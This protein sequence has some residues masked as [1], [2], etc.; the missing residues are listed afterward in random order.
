MPLSF[1]DDHLQQEGL[2]MKYWYSITKSNISTDHPKLH[3]GLPT[4]Q[5]VDNPS[6]N[7]E[8]MQQGS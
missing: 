7:V 2:T 3:K 4:V 6:I 1:L 5:K 8:A